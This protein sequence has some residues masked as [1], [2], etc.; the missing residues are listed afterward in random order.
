MTRLAS[1]AQGA[2]E[3]NYVEENYVQD[4]KKSYS[5]FAQDRSTSYL[6]DGEIDLLVQQH[7]D[8]TRGE[9]DDLYQ[10]IRT[11]LR[12]SPTAAHKV[13]HCAQMSPRLSPS[14]VL[15]FLSHGKINSLSNAWRAVIVQYGLAITSFH[16]AQRLKAYLQHRFDLQGELENPGH[17]GWDPLPRPDWL[18]LEVEN[19]ILIRQEQAEIADQMIS[20][21]SGMNSLMELNM[22]QG[23]SSIVPIVAATIADGSKLA[24][25][26]VLKSLSTQMFHLLQTKLGGLINRH[27]FYIP[28]SRLLKLTA[29]LADQIKNL[30]RTCKK[31]GG[32]LLV[33]PEHVLFFELLGLDRALVAPGDVEMGNEKGNT[34]DEGASIGEAMIETQS[35]YLALLYGWSPSHVQIH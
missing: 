16:R 14:I 23:K 21:S 31:T 28:I 26:I 9:V 25:V 32:V 30:Y 7:L 3:E 22:G 5:A 35:T 15:S 20:P 1:R 17:V 2:Y 18:L 4:L 11:A 27:I 6:L 8:E 34:A 24:R 19:N 29:E 10:K 33:Q 13:Y 12:Y